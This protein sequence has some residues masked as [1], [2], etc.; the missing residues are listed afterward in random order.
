M[1][2]FTIDRIEENKVV[3]ECENGDIIRLDRTSLPKNVRE[4]DVLHFEKGSYFLNARETQQ[5]R[6]KIKRLMSG[7]FED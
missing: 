3:L 1:K 4:G 6:D 7:L 2:K 5:R